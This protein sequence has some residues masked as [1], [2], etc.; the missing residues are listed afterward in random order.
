MEFVAQLLFELVLQVVMELLVEL[1]AHG[2]K[3]KRPP[4]HPA[5]AFGVY[6]LLGAGSGALSVV[7]FHQR[8]LEEAWAAYANLLFTPLAVGAVMGAIGAWRRRRGD[9]LVRLDQFLYGYTFALSFALAR[10]WLSASS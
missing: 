8:F 3:G 4:L 10:L 9:S 6:V 5:V 7:F 1:G 2:L